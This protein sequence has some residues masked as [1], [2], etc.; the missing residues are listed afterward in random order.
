MPDSPSRD[1]QDDWKQVISRYKKAYGEYTQAHRER[2]RSIV[3]SETGEL[4]VSWEA[5]KNTVI[6]PDSIAIPVSL[7]LA[8]LRLGL[9]GMKRFP[10]AMDVPSSWV[11]RSRRLR[12]LVVAVNDSDNLRVYHMPFMYRLLYRVGVLGKGSL[13]KEA[14]KA[15]ISTTTINIRLAGIDCPEG[16]HFGQPGQPYFEQSKKFLE[17]LAMNRIVTFRPHKI[18]QYQRLVSTVYA[19]HLFFFSKSIGLAMVRAGLATV[20]KDAG[21]EYGGQYKAL[22][23]AEHIAK[24]QYLGM[25]E[26]LRGGRYQSPSDYKKQS[27]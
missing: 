26:Q 19:P 9:A 3:H 15:P 25:W 2:F 10:T 21:A 23:R 14:T 20:Y 17:G 22:S 13:L 24:K 18:D 6:H 16:P 27:S 11:R 5:L 4:D 8:G 12:G 7:A 1:E